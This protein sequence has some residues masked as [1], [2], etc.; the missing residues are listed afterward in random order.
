ME[1]SEG[2][3]RVFGLDPEYVAKYGDPNDSTDPRSML[4]SERTKAGYSV[5]DRLRYLELDVELLFEARG[6]DQAE[7]LALYAYLKSLANPIPVSSHD[8]NGHLY[9]GTLKGPGPDAIV[10]TKD[11]PIAAKLIPGYKEDPQ[12]SPSIDWVDM[13][14]T[15][16]GHKAQRGES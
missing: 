9:A 8:E 14:C 12:W 4:P 2:D 5:E 16:E 11:G 10:A 6:R 1:F 3:D 15:C 13:N 7:K